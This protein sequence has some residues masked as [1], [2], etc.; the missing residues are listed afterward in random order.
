MMTVALLLALIGTDPPSR[1]S[2]FVLEREAKLFLADPLWRLRE[3]HRKERVTY[4]DGNLLIEDLTFGEKLLIRTDQK[5]VWRIDTLGGTYS[6][7]TFDQVK[8]RQAEVLK[9]IQGTIDRV[10]GTQEE[11]EIRSL[12]AAYGWYESEPAAEVRSIGKSVQIAGR[13][14]VG[15]DLVIN[16][17]TFLFSQVYVDASLPADGYFATLAQVSTFPPKVLDAL[18]GLG[19]V[20][21]RGRERHILFL[22]RLLI[23]LETTSVEAKE[24][25]A[26]TFAPPT[27][28]RRVPLKGFEPAEKRKIDRPKTFEKSFKEDDIDRDNNPLKDGDK[29]PKKDK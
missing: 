12:L 13:D 6:E 8:A 26:E 21:L 10:K 22:D 2:G 25:P 20:P 14:C 19:G 11:G 4:Q 28:L 16:G 27:G 5:K 7:L 15:K 17:D 24:I 29:P 23:D 3:I 1:Q 9:E 18:Q